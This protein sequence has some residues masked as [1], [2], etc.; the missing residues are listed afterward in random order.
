MALPRLTVDEA[1]ACLAA[2]GVVIF[3][4]ESGY[5]IGCRAFDPAAVARVVAVKR[6]PGGKPLPVLLPSPGWL[7]RS[8]DTP[9]ALLAEQL[10]PGPLTLV[11]PAFPGLPPPVTADTNMVGVRVSA[12]PVARTLVERLGPMV[13]TSANRT[14]EPAAHDAIA[15]DLAGLDEVDGLVDGGVLPPGANTVV[16]LAAGDLVFYA[17]GDLAEDHVRALWT[18]ARSNE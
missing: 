9:L 12:H 11:V 7:S 2:G 1:A 8:I 3:P 5:V 14:G 15:C 18:D 10:W 13:A 4:T 16:G 6:R 17:V